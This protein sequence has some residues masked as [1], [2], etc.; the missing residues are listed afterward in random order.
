MGLQNPSGFL[1]LYPH[2]RP[3]A[4]GANY[5][6]GGTR[7]GDVVTW[8]VASLAPDSSTSVQLVVTATQTIT[9]DD[10]RATANGNLSAVGEAP[11][12]TF[13]AQ[14]VTKYY[15]FG[16]TRA[17]VRPASEARRDCHAA[18]RCGILPPRR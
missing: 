13:V 14:P 4:A 3:L 12:V 10:H 16:S 5:V 17:S 1:L 8:A 2:R 7:S 6:S 11:V 18:W 9:N 15:Y